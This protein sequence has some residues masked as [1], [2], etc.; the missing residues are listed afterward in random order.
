MNRT[1]TYNLS[2]LLSLYFLGSGQ[3]NT[4]AYGCH[5]TSEILHRT[6][7][8][9]HP[10]FNIRDPTFDIRHPRFDIRHLTSEI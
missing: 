9:R 1:L 8:I 3:H 7:E 4:E 6:S 5:P 2:R 10:T